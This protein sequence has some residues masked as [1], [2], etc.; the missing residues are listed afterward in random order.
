MAIA[1]LNQP[2]TGRLTSGGD[3]PST[4]A[5]SVPVAHEGLVMTSLDGHVFTRGEL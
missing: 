3:L 1:P 4:G 2:I 5:R